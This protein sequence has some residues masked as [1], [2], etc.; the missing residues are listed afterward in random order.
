MPADSSKPAGTRA[1]VLVAARRACEQDPVHGIVCYVS[2]H[3]FGHAVRVCE[4]L[5]ALHARRPDLPIAIRSP[6][7]PWFFAFNLGAPFAHAAVQLDVGVVQDDSLTVDLP[8][9]RTAYAALEAR[10]AALIGAEVEALRALRPRLVFADIPAMAFDIAAALDVPGVAMTNFAWD[11]IYADY[12]RELAGFAPLVAALRAAYRRATVLYRLPLHGGLDEAFPHI[13][14]VP[15]V[16]RRASLPREVVRR[17]LALPADRRLVLLSFGGL[18]LT[19]EAVPALDGVGFVSTG[20]A[21]GRAGPRGCTVLGH[22]ALQAAGVRYEDLVG[23]VDAVIT[24]PGYGIVAECLA[25][26]T[27]VV[28]T[29]RGRFAEYDVLVAGLRRHAA[30]AY[31]SN[32]DLR[33]GRWQAALEAAWAMPYPEPVRADGAAVVADALLATW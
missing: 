25:N 23:A 31:L 6:L 2:G 27:P 30:H 17:R 16:A 5:R 26:R 32:D 9:T 18:G 24:K 15:F 14:D 22:D 19:L 1:T 28:Y 3:G 33:A 13:V 10:R 7:A 29:A 21:A 4:V 11:W 12:A 8:A 20:G